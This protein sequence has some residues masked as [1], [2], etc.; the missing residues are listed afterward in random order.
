MVVEIIIYI[1]TLRTFFNHALF[2]TVMRVKKK[3][4]CACKKLSMKKLQTVFDNLN[5][6]TYHYQAVNIDSS[7]I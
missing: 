5:T 2:I 3:I 6:A 7:D 4:M 1:Y